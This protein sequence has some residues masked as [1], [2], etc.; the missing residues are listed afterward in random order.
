MRKLSLSR[1][2]LA[3]YIE[4]WRFYSNKF[5]RIGK[6]E[7]WERYFENKEKKRKEETHFPDVPWT[8]LPERWFTSEVYLKENKK[9]LFLQ[10]YSVFAL[11]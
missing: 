11:I 10:Y 5:D 4:L 7:E 6:Q 1:L 2:L 3:V 9:V 8:G